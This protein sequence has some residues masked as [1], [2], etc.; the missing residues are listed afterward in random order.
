M[1]VF[2][3]AVNEPAR[4]AFFCQPAAAGV[5]FSLQILCGVF[6]AL[7]RAAFLFL[8]LCNSFFGEGGDPLLQRRC[9]PPSPN[10]SLLSSTEACHCVSHA[11]LFP[12]GLP[13]VFF[14]LHAWLVSFF[15]LCN[16][17]FGE[18]KTHLLQ[19]RCSPPS[20]SP[21]LLS[22]TEA[23]RCVSHANLFLAGLPRMFFAL[24][25]WLV[26]FLFSVICF[27]GREETLF[28]RGVVSLPPPSPSPLQH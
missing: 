11:N 8:I 21:S 9:S 17:L 1:T 4:A 5:R 15:I 25:A 22:S 13:R 28:F 6:F 2:V 20:P 12:A 24:H 27:L 19:R 18:E 10:P 26:S 23:C 14:A 7:A 16:M 3:Q